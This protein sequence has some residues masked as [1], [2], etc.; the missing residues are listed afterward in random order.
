MQSL[1]NDAA[2][3]SRTPGNNITQRLCHST[4]VGLESAPAP[5]ARQ[6]AAL[7][8]RN[9][10]L[11]QQ[12]PFL[13]RCA[14]GEVTLAALKIFLAQQGKYSSY[15]TRYLC[16]LISNLKDSG[17]VL[18]LAQNLA[19]ELG[20]GGDLQEPHSLMYARMLREFDIDLATAPML[21]ATQDLI[22][23]MF[24]YCRR[25]NPAY[26]LAALCLGAEA[27]VPA[28]YRDLL[29]GFAAH[30]VPLQQ[31][32]FFRIHIECDDGHSAIMSDILVRMLEQDR[33]NRRA[34]IEASAKLVEARL[35]FFTNIERA[36]A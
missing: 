3:Y 28:V 24:L 31:L 34:V 26:G 30:D 32:E 2:P 9:A 19:E 11:V 8:K 16:A 22:D 13:R 23:T 35:A 36:L 7:A 18:R 17:D 29:Q 27:I 33:A 21:P 12:H 10:A 4:S 20:L 6:L 14:S 1:S 25:S 5:A 15:F